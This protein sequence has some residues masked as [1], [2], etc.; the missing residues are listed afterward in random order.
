MI[1]KL[2]AAARSLMA[3]SLADINREFYGQASNADSCAVTVQKAFHLAGL[4][5]LTP[6]YSH[7]DKFRY[8]TLNAAYCPNWLRLAKANGPWVTKDYRAGDCLLFDWDGNGTP[9]HIGI[10]EKVNTD[11]TFA[12]IEGNVGTPPQIKRCIRKN[13]KTILGAFR[14]KY[15]AE[16]D[17]SVVD[18][19]YKLK[20]ID[21]PQLWRD[22]LNGDMSKLRP[23]HIR[24]LPEK[25]YEDCKG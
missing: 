8:N 6:F 1:E 20:E 15:V 13:D 7:G 11:Y 14:P 16:L 18:K 22:V 25:W 5:H 17:T 21:S 23:E 4:E 10:L 19:L 9:N 2:L 24:A 3:K 12:T